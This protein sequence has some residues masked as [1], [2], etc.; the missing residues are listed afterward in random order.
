MW[1]DK[2]GLFVVFKTYVLLSVYFAL[3]IKCFVR[4][5]YESRQH[6]AEL[7]NV[8]NSAVCLWGVSSTPGPK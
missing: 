1:Y 5:L 6:E 3:Q 7:I 2:M 8:S 4:S